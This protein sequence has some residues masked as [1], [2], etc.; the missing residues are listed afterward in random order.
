VRELIARLTRLLVCHVSWQC[1]CNVVIDP[2]VPCRDYKR[3]SSLRAL[4]CDHYADAVI[5]V[6]SASAVAI[7]LRWPH[8][9]DLVDSVMKVM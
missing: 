3:S 1:D 8:V 5:A 6:K 7:D 4:I 9:E 2:A